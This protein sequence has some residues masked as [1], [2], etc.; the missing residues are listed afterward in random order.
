[1]P[2]APSPWVTLHLWRVPRR[3]IPR[4]ALRVATD[5]RLLRREDGLRFAKVLGTGDGVTFTPRD[6][7][8]TRWG[9][10]TCWSTRQDA[11]D[12]DR[13]SPV[14]RGWEKLAEE[15]FRVDLRTLQARGRWGGREPFGQVRPAGHDGRIAALTRA[16]LRARRARTFYA[17]V[18]AVAAELH[19]N[20]GLRYAVGISEAP[21]G[22]QGTFSIWSSAA[23]LQSFAYAGPQ[24]RMAIERTPQV[25]WYREELF[26]RFAVEGGRGTVDGTDPL[27]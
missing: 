22:L 8:P 24:H 5:A 20:P 12:F 19:R 6:A 11:A 27:S 26:A 10:L 18:P 1:M 25:G 17:A 2:A 14:V 4:A 9:L 21:I 13:R 16:R 15:S 7:T 3:Y 23:A